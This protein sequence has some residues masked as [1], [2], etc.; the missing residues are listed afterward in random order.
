LHR[1]GESNSNPVGLSGAPLEVVDLR[2]GMVRQNRVQTSI[3][4]L[5]HT[6]K[7]PDER[8]G[9]I[10]SRADVARRVRG[11]GQGIHGRLVPLELGHW[12]GWEPDVEDDDF[13]RIHQNRR[14]VTR[15][16][17][18]PA[19]AYE[20]HLGVG[21][22]VDNGGMLLVPEKSKRRD[23][24]GQ[25]EDGK[26]RERKHSIRLDWPSS[27][28]SSS[29]SRTHAHTRTHTLVSNIHQ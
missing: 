2:P 22:L 18:V 5:R 21:R 10:P 6:R 28:S 16:L 1:G 26:G 24:S 23:E 19:Q 4:G 14:H 25:Q 29:S 15:V 12:Q 20:W 3:Q 17:L 13:R 9:V 8:L 11:P 27:S 7:V